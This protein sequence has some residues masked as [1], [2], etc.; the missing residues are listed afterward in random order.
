M[1]VVPVVAS[2]DEGGDV[3]WRIEA[4]PGSKDIAEN[5]VKMRRESWGC[6][7]DEVNCWRP[8]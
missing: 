6:I 2:A 4:D 5:A 7:T 1:D 3:D 8:E